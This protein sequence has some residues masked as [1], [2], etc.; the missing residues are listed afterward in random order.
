MDPRWERLR[1]LTAARIGLQRA[2]ASVTTRDHL[3][4]L[5]AHALAR[6]AVHGRLDLDAL[7]RDVGAATGLATLQVACACPDGATFLTR[8]D[9]GRRL[10]PGSAELLDGVGGTYDAVFLLAGGL[11]AQAV[12]RHAAPL[13]A[14]VLSGLANWRIGP[15]C[16]AERGRVALGDEVARRLGARL[17]VVL[18]GERPG[19]SSPDSLG[20]YLTWEPG[21]GRMDAERNC[22]SNIRP[23]GLP[24]EAAA[25]RLLWLMQAAQA[26]RLTGVALKDESNRP[27]LP[28]GVAVRRLLDDPAT[29]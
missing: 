18:I 24:I 1:A 8:P 7:A 17:A 16:L 13:L 4:F 10:A 22:L 6:D 26:R 12:A 15:V 9:M 23:E 19:L 5:A 14:H 20:A 27:A 29:G 21:R 28:G 2:G 11:S 25:R 3:A